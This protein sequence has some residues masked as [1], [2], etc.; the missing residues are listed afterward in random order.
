MC[1]QLLLK[2]KTQKAVTDTLRKCIK[3]ENWGFFCI[4]F[5]NE[6]KEVTP[7]WY[8]TTAMCFSTEVA[9]PMQSQILQASTEVLFS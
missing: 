7:L 3:K 2:I 6:Q 1:Y 4:K 5:K 9:H 8:L